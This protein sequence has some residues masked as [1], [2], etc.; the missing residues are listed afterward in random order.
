MP[1]TATRDNQDNTSQG[2]LYL[3]FELGEKKWQLAFTTGLGQRPRERTITAR[4]L[5]LLERE[6]ASAKVR[7]GLSP[8]AR[9][10]SCYE[11]GREGFWLH[12]AVTAAGLENVVADSASIEVNRRLRRAKSDRLD[13]RKLVEMLVR[14][15]AGE[16]RVWK[17]VRVPGEAEEDRRQLH[18][19]LDTARSERTRLINRLGGLLATQGVVV[20]VGSGFLERLRR[21]RRWNGSAIPA[22]LMSR[23]EREWAM[24][25]IVTERI[26][27]LE[28][29]RREILRTACDG[30]P[31]SRMVRQLMRLRGIGGN[32]SWL[33][34]ME[35]FAWR[36]LRNRRELGAL[37][38]LTPTPYQSGGSHREQGIC[39]AGNR[40]LR[41]M[42][43][44]IA[45]CWLRW[46]PDSALSRWYQK[47]FGQ[48]G[49]RLRRIGIVA[50]ARKLL[51]ALWRYAETGVVPD[52]AVLKA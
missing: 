1:T 17:V 23:L 36:Q 52:G 41:T 25:E 21:S 16:R 13:V 6:I 44:E 47:R 43:V 24:V 5:L 8:A 42:A 35:C 39:K 26:R 9:V 27:C 15:S 10:V 12:R 33:F 48:G 7:F 3:A 34:V 4:S 2:T 40:R 37:A 11:A 20:P 32:S 28:A 14:Y 46:Q 51:I 18:R 38:G 31:A 50:L 19:E 29:A 49:S 22:A 45:W 30:D